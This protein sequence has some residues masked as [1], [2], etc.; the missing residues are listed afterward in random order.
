MEIY[1]QELETLLVELSNFVDGDAPTSPAKI[2]NDP[3]QNLIVAEEM[4]KLVK[5][6]IDEVVK[7]LNNIR[8]V[9]KEWTD[10]IKKLKSA[11]DRRDESK[12]LKDFWTVNDGEGI[13]KLA[14]TRQKALVKLEGELNTSARG[15]RLEIKRDKDAGRDSDDDSTV[16]SVPESM[17]HLPKV[18]L[19]KFNGDHTKFYAFWD[20]FSALVDKTK[21]P[22]VRKFGTLKTL[23]EGEPKLYVDPMY[24]TAENYVEAKEF[25]EKKYGDRT[26]IVRQ[27]RNEIYA[28]P[29]CRTI[30]EIYRFQIKSEMLLKQLEQMLRKDGKLLESEEMLCLLEQKLP[31]W[32]LDKLEQWK[33]LMPSWTLQSFR[34]KIGELVNDEI[35]IRQITG[36]IRGMKM[37]DNKPE[38]N[39]YQGGFNKGNGPR[40]GPTMGFAAVSNLKQ[41]KITSWLERK[42]PF[43]SQTH[44][45]RDCK[46]SNNER[47]INLNKNKKCHK[48]FGDG[49]RGEQC[50]FTWK[51][52]NCQKDHSSLVCTENS[53]IKNV[54]NVDI[55]NPNRR[56]YNFL[57]P[58]FE[59]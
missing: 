18:N 39:R 20:I 21:A 28:L 48:C 53:E 19:P 15:F 9:Y 40:G 51:C 46:L 55:Y 42:C 36:D 43:C 5:P 17:E 27:L 12:I 38:P 50:K 32:A 3:E 24:T 56:N 25:L 41:T 14:M 44:A 29:H 16:A 26:I 31:K 35:R 30:D 52:Y 23:L 45:P 11:D 58:K 4:L 7:L 13:K 8:R 10:E 22:E 2:D 33:K 59:R 54:R 6:S 34:D 49:H 37:E 47:K 1:S 57:T